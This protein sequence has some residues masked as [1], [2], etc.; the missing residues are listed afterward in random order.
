MDFQTLTNQ[1][2]HTHEA[3]Q[4]RAGS[5]VNMAHTIRNW[6]FGHYIVEYEQ[7]GKDYAEYGSRL[8][9]RVSEML[10]KGGVKGMSYTNPGQMHQNNF[11]VFQPQRG[12][13]VIMRGDMTAPLGLK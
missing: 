8:L 3:M 9:Y 4:K 6:F 11:M 12:G 10:K 7:N 13:H 1:L 2:L 5:A